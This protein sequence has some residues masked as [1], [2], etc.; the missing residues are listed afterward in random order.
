[1]IPRVVIPT[2]AKIGEN[3]PQGPSGVRKAY[4][5]PRR[6]IPANAKLNPFTDV[7]PASDSE[8]GRKPLVG[9]LLV[10]AGARIGDFAA[11]GEP[12]GRYAHAERQVFQEALLTTALAHKRSFAEWLISFGLH[13][14]IIA[15]VVLLPLFFTHAIDPQQ[16]ELTYLV[17]PAAPAPPPPPPPPAAAAAQRPIP[18]HVTPLTAK[19]TMPLSIP[20]T[21]PKTT[22]NDAAQ[23]APD[24][25]AGVPGG[26]AGGIPG[27]Q[28]GGVLGGIL[29]GTGSAPPPQPAAEAA[30]SGPLHLGGEVKAPRQLYT[31]PP[32]YPLLARQARVEG[33]VQI[34][35]VIDKDGNVVQEHA[36]AGPPLLID[37]ALEAVKHWKYQP[38]YLNG[39]AWPI[40]LTI[41][42]TFS[43]S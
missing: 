34:D 12:G 2:G 20:K 23:A 30:P 40:E 3:A 13:A 26:V 31:P 17:A 27:G 9:K 33:D 42:V 7:R 4:L 38:T 32:R 21:I 5:V 1:M 8:K 18:R 37:A 11:Q 29:G 19:L 41:N 35:A 39:V 28:I 6:L 14:A 24:I 36:T 10:P 22:E 15:A 16:L 43:L 25:V